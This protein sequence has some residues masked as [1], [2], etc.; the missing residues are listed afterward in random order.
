MRMGNS[1][2]VNL[3]QG[4]TMPN[5]KGAAMCL[6]CTSNVHWLDGEV[7]ETAGALKR[8]SAPWLKSLKC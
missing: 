6:G 8:A 7:I 5:T 3:R 4:S 1:I 2:A